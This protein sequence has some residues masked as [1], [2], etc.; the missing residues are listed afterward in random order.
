[1]PLSTLSIG[2]YSFMDTSKI[3][4]TNLNLGWIDLGSYTLEGGEQ[5]S[6]T[7]QSSRC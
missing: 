5:A 2:D 6:F 7:M 4:L 3:V 1:M